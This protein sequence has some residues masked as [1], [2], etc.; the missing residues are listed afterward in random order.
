MKKIIS[1]A[2]LMCLAI[3][4]T[5]CKQSTRQHENLAD[6]CEDYYVNV[7]L[8]SGELM[9]EEFEISIS[10]NSVILTSKDA[11]GKAGN[12][13]KIQNDL[14]DDILSCMRKHQDSLHEYSYSISVNG[15]IVNGQ[16]VNQ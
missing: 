1:L 6:S 2:L 7:I 10:D 3:S 15:D 9:E 12:T 11:G 13:Y 5:A 16:H 14:A 8:Q 4:I